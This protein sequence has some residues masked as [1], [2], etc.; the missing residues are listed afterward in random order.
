MAG[1]ASLFRVDYGIA[2]STIASS[3]L[4][5]KSGDR[6]SS[7]DA[8]SLARPMSSAGFVHLHV[9][10]AYS[11]LKGAIKIPNLASWPRRIASRRWR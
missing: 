10:S 9:H 4:A 1:T 2:G 3:E 5:K 6:S 11:L 8:G 7:I